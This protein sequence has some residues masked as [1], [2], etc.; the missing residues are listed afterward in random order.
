MLAGAALSTAKVNGAFWYIVGISGLLLIAVMVVMIVF[1]IKYRRSRHPAGE[2]VKESTLLEVV[3]TVVPLLLAMTMFYFGWVDFKFIRNP[4]ADAFRVQVTGRQWAWTFRYDNGREEDVLR[5]PVGKPVNLIMT[6]MDVIHSFFVPAFRIKEDCVPGMK[7]HLWFQAVETGAFDVFCTEYCGLGHSHMRSKIFVL[8]AAEF[9]AWYAAP[10]KAGPEAA[11]LRLLRDKG[12]LGC[13]SI[14]GAPRVGPTF[15]GLLGL[16]QEVVT[17]G[18]THEVTV[19]DAYVAG[20]IA[21][22]NV[23][24]LAGFQPIMPGFALTKNEV[25]AVLAYLRTVK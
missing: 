13:H 23:D 25:E 6:S 3:W 5:V 19:D 11:G 18:R 21:E 20:Y 10:A 22:P 12:C 16:K 14:D 7:T 15:K 1:L 4:P 24:V 8:P 17:N 2:P 9:E